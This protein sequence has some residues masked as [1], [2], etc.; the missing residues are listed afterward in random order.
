MRFR[1]PSLSSSKE[2]YLKLQLLQSTYDEG[3]GDDD[4][5]DDDDDNDDDDDDDDYGYLKPSQIQDKLKSCILQEV[6]H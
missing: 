2:A 1:V 5:D 4:D 6:I 3:E